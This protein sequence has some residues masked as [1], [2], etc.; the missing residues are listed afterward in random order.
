MHILA[1]LNKPTEGS[2]WGRR[3]GITTLKDS[4][5][6]K[7]RRRHIGFVFQFFNLLPMLTA[8]ENITLPLSIAG[9][10]VDAEFFK[11]LIGKVGLGDRLGPRPSELSGGQQQRVAIARAL[12]S[13]TDG[14]SSRTSR[15]AT[16]TRQ[17][18]P[19]ILVSMRDSV[20]SYGQTT[21][22]VTHEARAA[23]IADRI[24]FPGGRADRPRPPGAS[25][26][27]C[28]RRWRSS[29]AR[30]SMVRHFALKGLLG[31]KL[32]HR[33]DGARDRPRRRDDQQHLAGLRTR[34]TRRSTR[35][36]PTCA[37]ARRS[38]SAASRRST[39]PRGA[40]RPR[41]PSTRACW[42]TSA[43][44]TALPR[45]RRRR[46]HA[47][48]EGGRGR[49]APLGDVEGRLAADDERRALAHVGEDR[50]E[51]LVD[52][53]RE[54]V[55]AADHRDAEDDRE[56]R[57]RG[58]QLSPQQALEREAG[59]AAGPSP[60][61]PPARRSRAPARPAVAA[62]PSLSGPVL[63]ILCPPAPD[64][65]R[66][67]RNPRNPAACRRAPPSSGAPRAGTRPG[68]RARSARP[69]GRGSGRRSPPRAPR[70]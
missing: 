41:P 50:V 7:L 51:R 15:R 61:A 39:S 42:T 55:G 65:Q 16:S 59:H 46:Q 32:Q 31:R 5:L 35:S 56:R 4:D 36:S 29:P 13:P 52:R 24:L 34:S 25:S 43:R 47:L 23:A 2:V 37:R 63:L 48:V 54:D 60:A 10:K 33:A 20:D 28:S 66:R 44:S 27:R 11:D 68:G 14:T 18:D 45:P 53:V 64:R 17:P 67:P 62:G 12:V 70:A 26:T 9:E 38:S 19:E 22:M 69:R 8:E 6:T 57:Q 58:A 49:A 1:G 21:V 30:A 40:A 3:R